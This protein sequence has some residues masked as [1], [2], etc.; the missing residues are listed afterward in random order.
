MGDSPLG[1]AD[2][3]GNVWEWTSSVGRLPD[4][5]EV[6]YSDSLAGVPGDSISEER[7]SPRVQ[8]GGTFL[9]GEE[10]A[11]RSARLVNLPELPL[12]D[13]GFRVVRDPDS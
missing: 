6:S 4:G 9:A 5:T 8:K 13:F 10:Y 12:Q 2:L 3:S 11:R 7:W 1:L